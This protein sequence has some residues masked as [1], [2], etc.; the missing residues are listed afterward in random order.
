MRF[1]C[2]TFGVWIVGWVLAL[3]VG[4]ISAMDILTTTDTCDYLWIRLFVLGIL[5]GI[6]FYDLLMQQVGWLSLWM[7]SM[8]VQWQWHNRRWDHSCLRCWI[9]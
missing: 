9:V 7:A 2:Y 3:A 8:Y 1:T 6:G 5:V 4:A